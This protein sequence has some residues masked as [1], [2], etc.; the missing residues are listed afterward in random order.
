MDMTSHFNEISNLIAG[1]QRIIRKQADE[2]RPISRIELDIMLENVRTLYDLLLQ[3]PSRVGDADVPE[4]ADEK[5]GEPTP[6]VEPLEIKF[7]FSPE[8]SMAEQSFSDESVEAKPLVDGESKTEI[9]RQTIPDLFNSPEISESTL[10]Q[11]TFADKLSEENQ[12]ETLADKMSSHR[13]EG[14]KNAIGINEKFFFINELFDG[15]L[16]Q[17]T[18]TMSKL[19]E[20][21]SLALAAE[22]L[23]K[24]A[25]DYKWDK[26]DDAFEKLKGFVERKFK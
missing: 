24:Q 10:F 14:L 8:V 11:R 7:P 5:T 16:K 21:N 26:N 17:Y 1:L 20:A 2:N 25:A 3:I 6:E 12:A 18:E 23:E 22:Y 15:S 9:T 19:D 13:I 4:I